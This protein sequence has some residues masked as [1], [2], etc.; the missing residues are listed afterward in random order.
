[1]TTLYRLRD[2]KETFQFEKE[3]PLPLRWDDK[4]KTYMLT[5]EQKVQ[6][7]WF[8]DK[9]GLVAEII[10][11]STSDNV[12]HIDSFTVLPRFRGKGV[13]YELVQVALDWAEEH[14]YQIVTG[15]ARKGASWSIFQN[16]GAS[17]V[18]TY[19]NYRETGEDYML[20]KI[21]L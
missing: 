7:I 15:E 18:L 13:G 10:L 2:Y 11:S 17:P 1:M 20:F 9:A 5:Q 21:V 12:V 14:S 3:H 4:Y 19:T 16:L 6:G 8:K